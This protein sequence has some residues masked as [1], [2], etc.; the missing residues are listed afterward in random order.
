MGYGGITEGEVNMTEMELM[1][2]L[3][4]IGES[5]LLAQ[6]E[7]DG[8]LEVAISR[9][10]DQGDRLLAVVRCLCEERGLAGPWVN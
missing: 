2:A 10:I 5:L 1:V 9:C 3:V 4:E 8:E 6:A 7:S